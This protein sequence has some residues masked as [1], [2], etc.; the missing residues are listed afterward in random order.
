MN[1][2][3]VGIAIDF[4]V[5]SR[6]SKDSVAPVYQIEEERVRKGLDWIAITDHDTIA[7]AA[8]ELRE[9]SEKPFILGEEILTLDRNYS[10][11]K[12]E[13]IGLFLQEPIS[14]GM[15]MTETVYQIGAQ[16]GIVIIPHPFE[17]WRH[18]AG[19]HSRDVISQCLIQKIPV[20]IEVFNAR[21][22]HRNN[23]EAME[24]W[25]GYQDKGVLRTAGSDAHRIPEIGR[26]YVCLPPFQTKKEFLEA[27]KQARIYGQFEGL[28]T[29]YHRLMNRIEVVIGSSFRDLS[30]RVTEEVSGP[31]P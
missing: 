16:D 14:P 3:R 28:G 6:F 2:E 1:K 4:H 11:K 10:G 20:A 13:I 19:E 26:Y 8:R 15:T 7:E 22:F 9:K 23:I 21:S 29:N 5:H 12:I 27:L 18:G 24:F 31:R 25:R 17:E 30:R